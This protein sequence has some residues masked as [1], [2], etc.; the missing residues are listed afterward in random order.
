MKV[1]DQIEL[2][3]QKGKI[4]W[5]NGSL[6]DLTFDSRMMPYFVYEIIAQAASLAVNSTSTDQY[7][8]TFDKNSKFL[9]NVLHVGN[10]SSSKCECGGESVGAA[11]H[12]HWCSKFS[13]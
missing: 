3:G 8:F 5:S 9:E 13:A 12:S 7:I 11:Y 6:I 10:S 4:T 1:G 2:H